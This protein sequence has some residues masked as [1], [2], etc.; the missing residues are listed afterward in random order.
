MASEHGDSARH[1]RLGYQLP[2]LCHPIVI[3]NPNQASN[4]Q[5]SRNYDVNGYRSKANITAIKFA[6]A[7]S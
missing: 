1:N 5:P 6:Y 7:L 2:T 3:S 4:N